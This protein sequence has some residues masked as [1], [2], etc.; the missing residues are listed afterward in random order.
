MSPRRVV[1]A[2]TA[3]GETRSAAISGDALERLAGAK[4]LAGSEQNLA[5][6]RAHWQ[7][8]HGLAAT[9]HD[10]GQELVVIR[11]GDIPPP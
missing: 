10:Q 2:Y 3:S 1:F 4:D 5:A 11:V 7:A 8:I 6:Y 9:K